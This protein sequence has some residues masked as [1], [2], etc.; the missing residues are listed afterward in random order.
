MSATTPSTTFGGIAGRDLEVETGAGAVL[1]ITTRMWPPE[2]S[3]SVSVRAP[4]GAQ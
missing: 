3:M 2:I 1:R 4:S